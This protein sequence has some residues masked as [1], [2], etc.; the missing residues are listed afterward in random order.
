MR[1]LLAGSVGL[2]AWWHSVQRCSALLALNLVFGA[3]DGKDVDARG[4]MS[5]LAG[6]WYGQMLLLLLGIGFA[7][8]AVPYALE[9]FSRRSTAR[10]S[11]DRLADGARPVVY[12]A[13]AALAI[14]LPREPSARKRHRPEA[15]DLDC[16]PARVARRG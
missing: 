15:A 6:E 13:L 8:F 4:V 9:A 1:T 16:H 14:S 2:I 11:S 10:N 7:G 3:R 12:G 5:D